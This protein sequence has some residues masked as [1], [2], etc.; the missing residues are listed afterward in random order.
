MSFVCSSSCLDK[1]VSSFGFLSKFQA[2]IV[3]PMSCTSLLQGWVEIYISLNINFIV[4]VL[5]VLIKQVCS[6]LLS[7]LRQVSC[8]WA[9]SSWISHTLRLS[10]CFTFRLGEDGLFSVV[11]GFRACF[12]VF[13]CS[14]PPSQVKFLFLLSEGCLEPTC[15]S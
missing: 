15:L 8:L 10:V 4:L 13:A 7:P 2:P 6:F 14:V 12:I 9:T 5:T 3:H 11:T 1:W